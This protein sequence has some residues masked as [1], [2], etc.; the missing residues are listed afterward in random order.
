MKTLLNFH[1]IFP[2]D[3]TIYTHLTIDLWDAEFL[4]R[5]L[6]QLPAS[7]RGDCPVTLLCDYDGSVTI[8]PET[9]HANGSTAL[10]LV[11]SRYEGNAFVMRTDRRY[12]CDALMLGTFDFYFWGKYPVAMSEGKIY[13]WRPIDCDVL[14]LQ[15][16][17]PFAEKYLCSDQGEEDENINL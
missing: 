11:R 4:K 10:K 16:E 13:C 17:R 12:L 2:P 14:P 6:P 3:D 7:E 9:N 15:S 8:H 5:K 1:K